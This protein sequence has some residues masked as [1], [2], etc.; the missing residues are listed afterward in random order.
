MR[1]HEGRLITN[2]GILRR[3]R[4]L[5]RQVPPNSAEEEVLQRQQDA[6]DLS[7]FDPVDPP[8]RPVRISLDHYTSR[9][10]IPARAVIE[11]RAIFTAGGKPKS[12]PMWVVR[13]RLS[14]VWPIGLWFATLMGCPSLGS[15][16]KPTSLLGELSDETYVHVSGVFSV[17]TPSF[18][19]IEDSQAGVKFIRTMPPVGTI[20]AGDQV[21]FLKPDLSAGRNQAQIVE[22]F[23]EEYSNSLY[24]PRSGLSATIVESRATTVL[25][26]IGLYA[27]VNL[28]QFPGTGMTVIT[29]E[30]QLEADFVLHLHLINIEDLGLLQRS[31]PVRHLLVSSFQNVP[32]QRE[33]VD[34]HM[35]FLEGI[36]LYERTT[37]SVSSG[38]RDCLAL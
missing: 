26:R 22:A 20:V 4:A 19:R 37:G 24:P 2:G 29:A 36:E 28:P 8:V 30:G 18:S 33:D 1:K 3:C 12:T 16:D 10:T 27:K 17:R 7:R 6:V 35:R 32:M 5:E 15:G 23:V 34:D 25:G 31:M 14:M 13:A 38:A 11:G 9:D 21:S